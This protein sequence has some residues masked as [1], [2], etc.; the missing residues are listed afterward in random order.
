MCKQGAEVL[1]QP[2]SDV[3]SSPSLTPSHFPMA[4]SYNLPKTDSQEESGSLVKF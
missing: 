1:S 3:G 4:P 2:V